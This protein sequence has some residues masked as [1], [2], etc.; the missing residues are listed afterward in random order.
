MEGSISNHLVTVA[1]AVGHAEIV[2]RAPINPVV[3]LEPPSLWLSGSLGK[4]K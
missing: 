2:E 3:Y 1:I 4:D